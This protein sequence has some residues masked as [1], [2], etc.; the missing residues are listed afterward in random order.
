M[1]LNE[2]HQKGS[3]LSG[4]KE[5]SQVTT[6]TRNTEERR[7]AKKGGQAKGLGRGSPFNDNGG[8]PSQDSSPQGCKVTDCMCCTSKN[9]SPAG[10][11][12]SH[13]QGILH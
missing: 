3:G 2:L 5:E 12:D 4:E 7:A 10:A 8:F 1:C 9:R 11:G 6:H 13:C